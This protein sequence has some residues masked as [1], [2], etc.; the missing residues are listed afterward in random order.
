MFLII[1]LYCN[2]FTRYSYLSVQVSTD[3]STNIYDLAY[4]GCPNKSHTVNSPYIGVDLYYLIDIPD[5]VIQ[6]VILL[7]GMLYGKYSLLY[8]RLFR[9][10]A[11]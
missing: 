8:K 1:F 6:G 3:G 10:N 9:Y 7:N 4:V 2:I 5:F 11:S